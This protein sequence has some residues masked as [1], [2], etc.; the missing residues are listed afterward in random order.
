MP[1]PPSAP[2]TL[3][4]VLERIVFF[5]EENHF[6]IG[7][8]RP[9]QSKQT[10]TITGKL[11]AVQCG[12]TLELSG[13]WTQHTQY[14]Q[15]FKVD[16]FK[17][18]LP[19]DV[20]GIRKYLGSGLVQGIGKVYANKIVDHFGERTLKI[21]SEE[22]ARLKE[23]PGIGAQRAKSIKKAWEEQAALR[24][25]MMFLKTYGVGTAQCLKLVKNY[26]SAAKTILQTEPYRIAREIDQIGF[27]TADK[28]ALNLGFSNDGAPR[29]EA[30]ILYAMKELEDEGHTAYLPED[31]IRYAANLLEVHPDTV[32]NH[33]QSLLQQNEL[34]SAPKGALQLPAQA[35]AEEQIAR[36]LVNLYQQPS[37]LPPIILDK[38]IEW[39][40]EKAGFTFAL[41][42]S[43]ALTG[44]L[45]H[46]LS[47]LTGGP[48]TGK[49]TI[50]RALVAILHAKKV[51]IALAAPTGR[52][53]Q[54]M[55]EAARAHAQTI[56]RLLQF[57]PAEGRFLHRQDNPL[58]TDFLIVDEASM[59]DNKLAAALIRA[60]PANAHILLVG[61]TH[62]L[63]SVGA[64]DILSNLIDSKLFNVVR[65][66]K[67]FRQGQ[68]SAIVATAHGILQGNPGAPNLID[69]TDTIDPKKDL[70]FIRAEDPQSCMLCVQ[71]LIQD[72]LPKLFNVDAIT[73]IQTLAPMHKGT[74]GI[75]QLNTDLQAVLNP[76]GRALKFG[77][78]RFAE[79][80]KIIQT[81]NDYDKNIFNG[82]IGHVTAVNP[83]SGTLAA[84]FYAE[85]VDFERG[86]LSNLQLAYSIS[87]HK[88]QGSEFPIV[89]IPLL[90]QHFIMLQRNLLYT[91]IT[92]G[93]KKVFIVGDPVA[94]AMAV[95]NT[96]STSRKTALIEKIQELGNG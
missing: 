30:G 41:E 37:R 14:G 42:Q 13:T 23:V 55:S 68:R 59:L 89:V 60:V 76:H 74:V 1:K 22:S 61:D 58:R 17:S 77:M 11:P 35:I 46:K 56:H 50:L 38:A 64:G 51:R 66:E 95:N 62:Q 40:Q 10:V 12:E 44:A 3:T 45:T 52:A 69:D 29:V 93:R 15:Q 78:Q 33:L 72:V 20:Y 28:I 53:A 96:D 34:K 73:Q 87:I 31:L 25:V 88:S 94:Y 47:I 85:P 2:D 90:K 81:R 4:G 24:E 54:R 39:A 67:I 75:A 6:C 19:S 82:D 27:K 18:K 43:Q 21:I 16:Q 91:A 79:G 70:H 9:S 83:E 32:R 7:E 63:P 80:D 36:A 26:G 84:Q 5:N 8:F 92:R 86:D 71:R 48:G 49:T 65:L 57:D